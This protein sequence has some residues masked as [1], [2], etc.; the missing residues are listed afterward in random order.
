MHNCVY[1]VG[2]SWEKHMRFCRHFLWHLHLLNS[3][4]PGIRLRAPDLRALQDLNSENA[5]LNARTYTWCFFMHIICSDSFVKWRVEWLMTNKCQDILVYIYIY[6]DLHMYIYICYVHTRHEMPWW[7]S[8]GVK[9]FA[10]SWLFVVSILPG[11]VTSF[12]H[13]VCIF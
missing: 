6:L 12:H 8:L 13:C 2:I 1:S 7:G 11:I 9:Y 10:N 4:I 3:C 5:W